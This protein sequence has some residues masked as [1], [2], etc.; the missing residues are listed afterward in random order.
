MQIV[1]FSITNGFGQKERREAAVVKLEELP[2]GFGKVGTVN[3]FSV[4]ADRGASHM[5]YARRFFAVKNWRA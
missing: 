5:E 2:V 1:T 4:Y 3:G